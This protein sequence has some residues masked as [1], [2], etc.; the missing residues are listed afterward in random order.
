[1]RN[2]AG[3]KVLL[4]LRNPGGTCRNI[5]GRE[6]LYPPSSTMYHCPVY[7]KATF[8]AQFKLACTSLSLIQ[9]STVLTGHERGTVEIGALGIHSPCQTL[10]HHESC[11]VQP[12]SSQTVTAVPATPPHVP[13]SQYL[14]QEPTQWWFSCLQYTIIQGHRTDI[15][16]WVWC[17]CQLDFKNL[18]DPSHLTYQGY[19]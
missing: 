4:I 14:Q 10:Q 11:P 12:A 5:Y 9:V 17:I 1:M 3:H 16:V 8:R 6:Q 18:P 2:L 15:Y 7:F 19:H 13:C